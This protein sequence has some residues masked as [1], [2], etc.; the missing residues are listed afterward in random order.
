M[1]VFV[2][3]NNQVQI[4]PHYHIKKDVHFLGGMPSY[5]FAFSGLHSKYQKPMS[6]TF[7]RKVNS[8][9]SA[10]LVQEAL[11]REFT[12]IYKGEGW[13]CQQ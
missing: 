9:E 11:R 12:Y 1:N 6:T 2:S 3:S 4:S 10:Q 13:G 5:C 7:R 8:L